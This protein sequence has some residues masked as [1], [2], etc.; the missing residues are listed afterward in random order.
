MASIKIVRR[1][2]K[3][4]K[5]G[6]APLALRISE[7]Y[8]TNYRFTGQYVLEKDW[9]KITGRVKRSHSYSQKL[10]N[11]LLK[12]LTEANDIYFDSKNKLT[13]KQVKQKLKGAGGSKSFFAVASERIKNKYERGTFSVAKSELSILYNIEEF[14]NLNKVSG[15][16]V[17][18]QEIKARR[19]ERIS[20]GRKGEHSFMDNVAHFKNKKSL[21]FQ[22][23][24]EPFLDKYKDFCLV[25]LGQKTRTIT[26]Q[27]I[28]IRTLFNN[29]IKTGIVDSKYYPFGGEKEKICIGS[30]HKIGLTS[31]EIEKIEILK[32]EPNTSIW[33]T[34]NVWLIAFYF[35]GIRISDAVKLKWTDFKD[36][37]L[38]YVM[39][40]NDK[41]V[42][43]KIPEKAIVILKQYNS[44]KDQNN[45]YIFPFLNS[46]ETSNNEDLFKKTRN[47][48]K[49]FNKY[50]K[51]IAIKCKID[52]NL[53]NH[54]ARHSFG[55]IAGDRIHPLMLQKL[56]R[57][58]DLKTTLNYQ[59]NFIHRDADEALDS[60]LNF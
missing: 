50:L 16:D 6:T 49:L 38:L 18:I 13:T 12:K 33:H 14:L 29:A 2:N 31:N 41:P 26:N 35:A 51:R 56:Y 23:I 3:Q 19:K 42:S 27:L 52:K 44:V 47:A 43:L 30:S 15:K 59:S 4:R 25:Y 10:N 58:S 7:N 46:M 22:D 54:I 11:F 53:S 48:T 21:K 37:R 28:F 36:D 34:K 39:H 40:K 20:K 57:H 9:D 5:D 55:N 17:S 24:N 60:V 32:L 45:G 1:K 8:K